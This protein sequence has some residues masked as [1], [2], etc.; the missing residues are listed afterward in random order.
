M[1]EKART[2]MLFKKRITWVVVADGARAR[3]LERKGRGKPLA[4]VDEMSSPDSRRPTRDQ[5]TGKPGRGFSPISGRHEF[6]D[7]VDWHEAAKSEF[8]REL[9][10]RILGLSRE[11]A[12][13]EIILV[14]PPKALGELRSRLG[15]QLGRR[16]KAEINK[17]LTQLSVHEL[18]AR[19]KEIAHL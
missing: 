16:L 3:I 5:G 4:L 14:A 11:N 8:L 19:L 6:S 12:F 9:A 10:E 7:P 2:W 18:P 1:Q 17:D 15:G 13:D